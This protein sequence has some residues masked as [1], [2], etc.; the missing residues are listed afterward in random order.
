MTNTDLSGSPDTAATAGVSGGRRV[1]L[2]VAHVLGLLSLAAI[3]VQV[4]FAGLGAFGASFD[5][6]RALGMAIP[7]LA[8]LIMIAVLIARPG[9]RGVLLAVGLAV[10]AVVQVML[11]G[12]GDNSSEWFGAL[13]A[14]NAL[15]LIG[16]TGRIVAQA[17]RSLG[18][19]ATAGRTA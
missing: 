6:H 12:L 10:L 7:A 4:G 19:T 8:L 15:V 9:G 2:R 14:V 18:S 16:L 13:H 3:A 17:G 5:A 11:A 1:A